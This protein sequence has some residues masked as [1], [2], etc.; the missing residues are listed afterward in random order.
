MGGRGDGGTRR[1]AARPR[2]V[3]PELVRPSAGRSR[4]RTHLRPDPRGPGAVVAGAG[5][6]G[7]PPVP[8]D[9]TDSGAD[10][11]PAD[12]AGPDQLHRRRA[13]RHPPPVRARPERSALPARPRPAA[14]LP[15]HQGRVPRL[16]LRPRHGQR[17]RVRHV[18]PGVREEREV[19]HR[20]HREVRGP[21]HQADDVPLAAEHV[22][23]RRGHGVDRQQPRR[24]HVPAEPAA[25]S[26]GSASR[27]RS[28]AS[29]RSTSTPPR[30]SGT[31]TT[32]CCT[33]RPATAASG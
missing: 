29:S 25:R 7:V 4:G 18:R 8:E 10:R 20:P 12:A 23:A 11:P 14:P 3:R 27:R 28:T 22:P 19:L 30:P 33:S 24:E 1:R 31:A 32:G 2:L 17:L 21:Q 15:R 5:A 6:G 13:R 9:R 26:C 16:L